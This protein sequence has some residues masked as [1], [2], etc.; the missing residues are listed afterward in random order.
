MTL[1][2]SHAKFAQG[3]VDS[4]NNPHFLW[5]EVMRNTLFAAVIVLLFLVSTS[6]SVQAMAYV[7]VHT[8]DLAAAGTELRNKVLST[9]IVDQPLEPLALETNK[10][11][12]RLS[13]P[14]AVQSTLTKTVSMRAAAEN[15][16][17][18]AQRLARVG[19]AQF[20]PKVSTSVLTQRDRTVAF[21]VAQLGS[22][23]QVLV[24]L[25]WRLRSGANIKLSSSLSRNALPGQPIDGDQLTG[26]SISQPLLRGASRRVNMAGLEVEEAAYRIAR[27]NL[28]QIAQGLLLQTL[29][30]YVA[31]LQAQEATQQAKT[32]YD[33]AQGAY[34][35]NAALLKA[36]RVAKY[37]VLQS[38]SDVAAARLGVAQAQNFQRLGVRAL[39]RAIGNS[40]LFDGVNLVLTDSLKLDD[41]VLPN[42][43][44]IVDNAL[45]ASAEL[46][47]ARE[48]VV[49]AELALTLAKDALRPSLSLVAGSDRTSGGQNRGSIGL[50]FEYSLDRAP[51][52][53][54][55]ASAQLNVET[56]RAQ[57]EELRQRVRDAAI[58]SLQN[59]RF[60]RAQQSLARNALVL[61]EQ[62]L[63]AEVTRQRI[64]RVSQLELTNAQQALAAANR[65]LLEATRQVLRARNEVAQIDG[66]L[67]QR[68]G[69]KALVDRWLAQAQMELQP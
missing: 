44:E 27:R 61:A 51:Q 4:I 6:V 54:E 42:E 45:Q 5:Y 8:S 36:G 58:D 33:V 40:S 50:S 17:I 55:K 22:Q 62:Q 56:A 37:V 16:H 20:L 59:L 48:A 18:Q 57:L 41:D 9:P 25:N 35:L 1:F 69:V 47:G 31:A 19:R 15:L 53:L 7:P 24:D 67:L 26:I 52:L 11:E 29:D 49:Q 66:S 3:T 38:E 43:Q 13:L 14:D 21:N 23:A 34:E 63:D 46:F 28:E 65:Q 12:R 2:Y 39:A 10:L 30:A 68:W 64:G 32:A 60:T